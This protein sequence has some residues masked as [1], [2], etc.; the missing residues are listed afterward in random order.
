MGP[1]GAVLMLSSV[2]TAHGGDAAA[3]PHLWICLGG[4]WSIGPCHAAQC[5]SQAGRGCRG[6]GRQWGAQAGGQCFMHP[7][8]VLRRLMQVSR[9]DVG[10]ALIHPTPWVTLAEIPSRAATR[11][12]PTLLSCPSCTEQTHGVW[13]Q[14]VPGLDAAGTG[15]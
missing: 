12:A 3:E 2:F 4:S 15:Q 13:S 9:A 7:R 11:R 10:L 5:P 6:A 1:V 8:L 14:C